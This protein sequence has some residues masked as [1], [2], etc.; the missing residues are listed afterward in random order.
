M[1]TEASGVSSG[2]ALPE[3]GLPDM[4]LPAPLGAP[5]ELLCAT[6]DRADAARREPA[7]EAFREKV[8]ARFMVLAASSTY[9]WIPVPPLI[10]T[11]L[12]SLRAADWDLGGRAVGEEGG[13]VVVDECASDDPYLHV[14]PDLLSLNR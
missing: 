6:L 3:T 8:A 14:P 12:P 1:V 4:G 11:V 13:G 7:F 9:A 2:K 10:L 5:S